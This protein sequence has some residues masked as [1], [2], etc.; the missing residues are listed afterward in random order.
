MLYVPLSGPQGTRERMPSYWPPQLKE[1]IAR[2]WAQDPLDRPGFR[3]VLA[4]L[5]RMAESGLLA[6][7]PTR[8]GDANSGP[9]C[10]TIM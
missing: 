5:Q 4:G 7:M 8:P 2:C 10:C 1:L 9:G 6:G 3:E